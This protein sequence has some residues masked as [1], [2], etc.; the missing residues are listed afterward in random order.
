[1][2][3]RRKSSSFSSSSFDDATAATATDAAP[4]DDVEASTKEFFEEKTVDG[5]AGA[6][7]IFYA[8]VATANRGGGEGSSR[9]KAAAGTF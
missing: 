7:G 9:H 2:R 1:M 4:A 8:L 3:R 5:T 6:D